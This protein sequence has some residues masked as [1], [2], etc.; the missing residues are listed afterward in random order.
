MNNLQVLEFNNQRILL[1]SQL[2]EGYN[3]T[4]KMISNNFNN[5]KERF[6]EGKH[7]YVLQG[8][9]LKEFLRSYDLGLQNTN[10]IRTLYLWT[11]KGTLRHAKILDTDKAWEVYERLEETYFRVQDSKQIFKIPET[12]NEAIYA[13]AESLKTNEQLLPKAE[14]CDKVLSSESTFT[15]TDIAK[16]LG[17]SAK[18]LNAV[19]IKLGVQFKQGNSYYLMAKYQDKGYTETKTLV[20]VKSFNRTETVHQLRWKETGRKFIID[21]LSSNQ[22]FKK[23]LK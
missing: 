19:L 14:Y 21:L 13:L 2:A 23:D 7:Y 4:E 6:V 17:M 9:E 11:E 5:N 18:S 22:Q 3:A 8:E 16:E 12:Y 20:I 10:K 15:V 1:T